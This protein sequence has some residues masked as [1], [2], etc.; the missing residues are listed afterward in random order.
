[1]RADIREEWGDISLDGSPR[2][3]IGWRESRRLSAYRVRLHQDV[4]RD[5]AALCQSAVDQIQNYAER[6]FENF[7]ELDD[8]EY[9]WYAHATLPQS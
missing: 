9:F 4:N 1:M 3:L 5:L 8:D 6:A 2:M 7:A